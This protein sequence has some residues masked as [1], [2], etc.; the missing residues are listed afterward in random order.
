MSLVALA[1]F[2]FH[3]QR[4]GG[5]ERIRN[6][7]TRVEHPITVFVPNLQDFPTD[8]HKNLKIRY[9]KMDRQDVLDANDWDMAVA[10]RSGDVF[11]SQVAELNPDLVILEHPWQFDAV[12]EHRFLYD[13]HNNETRM[14]EK[15]APETVERTSELEELSL[16]ADHVTYCSELDELETE[17]PKT[18]IP[19]GTDIPNIRSYQG[20]DSKMLLFVGSGH[21]PN[22]TAAMTL[23]QIAPL[24]PDYDI[25]IAGGCSEAF[26]N[27]PENVKLLGH[28]NEDNLD[29]L[30]RSAHAFVNLVNYGSGTSLKIPKALSY[31][32]PVV[33]SQFG[34]R[35][36]QDS[37]LIAENS[38]ELVEALA[39]LENKANY[40]NHS[41]RSREA[42]LE[43]DWNIIGNKFNEVIEAML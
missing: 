2:R 29:L 15:I 26:K 21:P 30:F 20:L 40:K 36:H 33:S 41:D 16:E 23:A 42:S 3:D 7:L 37:C 13:A 34:A 9:G 12:G 38:Q 8:I 35:G 25:V 28:V 32:L 4:F 39:S 1:P 24:F 17:S 27:P 5:A 6:L 19:N 14:K 22:I 18:L 11:G 31:G 10:N 43:F